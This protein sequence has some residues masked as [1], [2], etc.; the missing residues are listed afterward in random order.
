VQPTDNFGSVTPPP[1]T[2]EETA[3]ELLLLVVLTA[4]AFVERLR[5]ERPEGAPSSMTIVHGL[6]ARYLMGRDDVTTVELAHHLG[7]TKQSTSEVVAALERAGLVRRVPHPSDG[8]ARVLVLT[9][10][11]AAKLADGRRRWTRLE[12]EWADL[13][14]R[15]RL[16]VVREALEAYLKADRVAR[17]T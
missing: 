17:S 6:A 12:D 11:G 10:K 16:D 4:K 2:G 7:I 15:E 13:V 14:G 3:D 8:R 1:A 9:D 5:A